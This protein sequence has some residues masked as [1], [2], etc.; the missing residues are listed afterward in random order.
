MDDFEIVPVD[1]I[2]DLTDKKMDYLVMSNEKSDTELSTHTINDLKRFE[3]DFE[4]ARDT[5]VKILKESDSVIESMC[6]MAK[7]S[8]SA[9][10]YEV[11]SKMMNDFA[12]SAGRLLDIHE[13]YRE[14]KE[15]V[16]KDDAPRVQNNTQN[17]IVLTASP[18]EVLEMLD[19]GK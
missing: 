5:I 14:I 11:L 10:A 15:V 17:N 16:D 2:D 6:L 1:N 9:R 13:R 19:K 12:N 3:D 18:L 7:S 8:D 4:L